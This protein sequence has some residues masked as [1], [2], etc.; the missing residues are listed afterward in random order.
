MYRQLDSDADWLLRLLPRDIGERKPKVGYGF[1]TRGPIDY[2]QEHD[3]GR[4]LR[5]M[6]P[7]R[8]AAATEQFANS[9]YLLER[10]KAELDNKLGYTGAVFLA[11]EPDLNRMLSELQYWMASFEGNLKGYRKARDSVVPGAGSLMFD[12]ACVHLKQMIVVGS[13]LR[14]WLLAQATEI[15]PSKLRSE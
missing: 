11:H 6:R 7:A 13:W 14:T 15:K 9:P 4:K 3:F 5:Q 12:Q 2:E 10:F 8:L 1:G